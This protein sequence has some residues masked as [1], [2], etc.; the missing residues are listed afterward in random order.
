MTTK[1]SVQFI[2]FMLNTLCILCGC[3]SKLQVF[4]PGGH[5]HQRPF[6]TLVWA[7]RKAVLYA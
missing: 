3:I 5:S 4:A 6:L 1:F 7:N 2:S